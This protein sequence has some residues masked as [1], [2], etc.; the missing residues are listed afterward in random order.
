VDIYL[1]LK[2]GMVKDAGALNL[3]LNRLLEIMIRTTIVAKYGAIL[4]NCPGKLTP[5]ACKFICNIDTPPKI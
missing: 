3:I 5:H 2:K 1:P 4:K